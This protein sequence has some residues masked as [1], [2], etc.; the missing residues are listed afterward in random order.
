MLGNLLWFFP[1]FLVG[2]FA[3]LV[4]TSGGRA[5]TFFVGLLG[6]LFRVFDYLAVEVASN[7]HLP[8]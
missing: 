7:F 2:F 6:L 5:A 8:T 3:T 4:C 1:C